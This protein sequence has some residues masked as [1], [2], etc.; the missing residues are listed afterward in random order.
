[1]VGRIQFLDRHIPYLTGEVFFIVGKE[2]PKQI[3]QTVEEPK[4]YMLI[5]VPFVMFLR[6][7]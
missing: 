2:Y 5:L 6:G 1:M 4:V 7:R 3:Q